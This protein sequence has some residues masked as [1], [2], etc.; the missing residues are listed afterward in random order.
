MGYIHEHYRDLE[1]VTAATERN[2]GYTLSGAFSLF[3]II[4]STY[5]FAI[6][7]ILLLTVTIVAPSKLKFFNKSWALLG[8]IL[9]K[10]V[11][12]IIM[13]V[14][15]ISVFLPIAMILNICRKNTMLNYNT[16]SQSYWI[17]KDP[18]TLPDPMKY[19]F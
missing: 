16:A 15:Y 8:N 4:Y 11:T 10:I 18:A 1:Q 13:L 3:A 19:Q 6:A 7:A 12:P 9:Q 5:A 14:I 2:F 17:H